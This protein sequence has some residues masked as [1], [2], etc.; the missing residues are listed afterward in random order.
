MIYEYECECGH[1]FDVIKKVAERNDVERCNQ[2]HN[3]EVKRRMIP[4][5]L[6]GFIGASDWDTAH[7]NPALGQGVRN[8]RHAKQV[9]KEM[10]MTEVGNEPVENIHKK[11]D[12]DRA[13]AR[14]RSYDEI[15]LNLGEIRSK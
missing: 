14:K 12:N 10:G 5:R 9:A 2:C 13:E 15:N 8:N 7:Y 6:G 3:N 1:K 4:S 11:F